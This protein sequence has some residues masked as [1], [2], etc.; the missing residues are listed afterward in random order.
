MGTPLMAAPCWA[1]GGGWGQAPLGRRWPLPPRAHCPLPAR[2]GAAVVSHD[3]GSADGE[4]GAWTFWAA[5]PATA[6]SY[7]SWGPFQAVRAAGPGPGGG[8]QEPEHQGRG[9]LTKGPDQE[10]PGPRCPGEARLPDPVRPPPRQGCTQQGLAKA[11]GGQ[12]LAEGTDGQLEALVSPLHTHTHRH[13]D[14]APRS[15]ARPGWATDEGQ[16]AVSSQQRGF[17]SPPLVRCARSASLALPADTA[18][19]SAWDPHLHSGTSPPSSAL[20]RGRGSHRPPRGEAALGQTARGLE[21][22]Q[23]CLPLLP[24]G[25]PITSE[26]EMAGGGCEGR[27]CAAGM[28]VT[29]KL[30]GAGRRAGH[31]TQGPGASAAGLPCPASAR[32]QWPACRQGGHQAEGPLW[33]VQGT[34]GWRRPGGPRHPGLLPRLPL[35]QLPGEAPP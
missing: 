5:K 23:S 33:S 13:T 3:F 26:E 25:D 27:P 6:A 20:L 17:Q 24:P 34:E 9:P 29:A 11:W 1:W 31:Q 2:P 15:S 8:K 12:D 19:L 28:L 22:P 16:W 4:A 18:L 21:G 10:G 30:A 35:L 32:P 14:P 7:L